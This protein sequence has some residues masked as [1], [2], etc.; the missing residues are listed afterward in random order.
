MSVKIVYMGTPE[1]AV[2]PLKALLMAGY[3][4]VGVVTV[5][6]RQKGRGLHFEASDVKKFVLEYNSS[7]SPDSKNAP[8]PILQPEKLRDE[9][10][11]SELKSL[12][13]DLFIVVAFR[14]LPECVWQMPPLGT[15]NLHASLLPKFRGAAPINWAIIKGEKQTGVTTFLIDNKI[16][17][18]EILLQRSCAIEPEENVG[19]LHD[20]LLSMGAS[21][22]VETVRGI[23]EGS[24]N[25]VKQTALLDT[26][27]ETSDKDDVL[28]CPMDKMLLEE[29]LKTKFAAPKL[30]EKNRTINWESPAAEVDR[31]VRGLSPYP[32]AITSMK[33]KNNCTSV[34]ATGKEEHSEVVIPFKIYNTSVCTPDKYN[35]LTSQE[36]TTATGDCGCITTTKDGRMFV[37][38]SDAYLEILELQMSG[39]KR[40]SAADFLRGFRGIEDHCF[41]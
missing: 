12:R 28:K 38:C 30:N 19:T 26:L 17:T 36:N 27:C 21:L 15:F 34:F 24:L 18:G 10:F 3:E 13:A 14:M 23:E 22:V 6:D 37:R 20:K 40:M 35:A 31:L 32:A 7:L 33:A 29:V 11:L 8:I 41:L 1:F 25:P 16:D 39:K 9:N 2:A 5:P 4:V